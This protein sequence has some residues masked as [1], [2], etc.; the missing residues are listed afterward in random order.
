MQ[1]RSSARVV[2]S[3][4]R[5]RRSLLTALFPTGLAAVGIA[6]LAQ[7]VQAKRIVATSTSAP[8]ASSCSVVRSAARRPRTRPRRYLTGSR[9]AAV[10]DGALVIDADSGSLIRTDTTGKNIAQAR[11]RRERRPAHLR[12]DREARVRR[13]S[14]RRIASSSSRSATTARSSGVDQD[15]GRAVRRR[16]VARSQD[17]V[18]HDD[19]RSRARRVRR[20]DRQGAVAHGA[21]SRAARHRGLARWHARARRVPRDRHGRSDRSARDA[22]RRARRAVDGDAAAPLPPLRQRRRQ[23]RARRVRGDVHGRPRGG[24]RRSSARRR[25]RSRTAANTGS[26][27]GGFEPPITHQLAFLGLDR[28]RTRQTTATIAQHQPRALAWDSAHDALYVAGIG[29]DSILQIKNA[30]QVGIAEGVVGDR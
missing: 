3:N 4:M 8:R 14:L 20:R 16:A 10:G 12:P 24:R 2:R 17:A 26:Y 22:Q 13:R 6:A 28:D 9:I 15:A 23:L 5:M 25:C 27:G 21:R 19:R 18:R 29:T 7:P 30:S 1:I 11:D